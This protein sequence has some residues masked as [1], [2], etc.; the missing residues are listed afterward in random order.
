MIYYI[1]NVNT[2][3]YF[4]SNDTVGFYL[5]LEFLPLLY[6]LTAFLFYVN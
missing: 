5:L 2:V 3:K 1:L 4:I 6:M